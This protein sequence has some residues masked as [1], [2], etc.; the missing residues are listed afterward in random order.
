MICI[1]VNI[2]YVMRKL[3]LDNSTGLLIF[4]ASKSQER[5]AEVTIKKQLGLTPAQWKVILALNLTDG[6]TQKD[7]AEKIFL[8]GSTLVPV[9]DK[10]EQNGMV[11]RK[12]DSKDRRVNRVFLTKQSEATVDSIIL[13]ILQLRKTIYKRV[14]ESEIV[15]IKN[16][17]KTIIKNSETA[18]SEIKSSSRDKP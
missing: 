17:L 13:I 8:D 6:L 4:L 3:D 2:V 11:E 10:M 5:L 14:S 7:L 16:I 12:A 9:I 1:H 18:I 15:L